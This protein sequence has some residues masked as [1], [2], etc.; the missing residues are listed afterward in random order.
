V[1]VNL[2]IGALAVAVAGGMVAVATSGRYDAGSNRSVAEAAPRVEVPAAAR[3]PGGYVRST[4]GH[5]GRL[6]TEQW[7]VSPR[8]I[9]V[10]RFAPRADP[11]FGAAIPILERLKVVADG[12]PV[13]GS[14]AKLSPAGDGSIVLGS[15]ART[16]QLRYVTRA[17]VLPNQPKTVGRALVLANPLEVHVDDPTVSGGGL[18][19]LAGGDVLNLACVSGNDIPQPCGRPRERG[20]QVD[21]EGAAEIGV[22]AQVDL[23]TA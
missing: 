16:I 22:F 5:H 2:A 23:P 15:A 8:P 7:I 21:L 20:W 18:V 10:L 17:A 19:R 13:L 11:G 6:V 3:R 14:A 9:S 12:R 4:I 1:L